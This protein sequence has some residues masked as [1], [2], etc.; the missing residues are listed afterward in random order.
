MSIPL[1]PIRLGKVFALI[2]ATFIFPVIVLVGT[3]NGNG[4]GGQGN[5]DQN[6]Y[7]KVAT[8]PDAGPA[9][10]LLAVAVGTILLFSVTR[11][12]RKSA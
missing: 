3:D 4:N 11:S 8:V 10:V 9:I 5:G 1:V 6:G 7:N 2:A 12:S